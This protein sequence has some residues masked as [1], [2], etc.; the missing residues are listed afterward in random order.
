MSSIGDLLAALLSAKGDRLDAIP[1]S[2]FWRG[3][4]LNNLA[5]HMQSQR[6]VANS[7][8]KARTDLDAQRDLTNNIADYFRGPQQ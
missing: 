5:Q 6:Q 3:V 4:G 2:P 7:Y 1:V 8:P